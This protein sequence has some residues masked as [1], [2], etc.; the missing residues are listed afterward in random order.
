MLFFLNNNKQI[1]II[2]SHLLQEQE[3]STESMTIGDYFR[4]SYCR[5]MAKN[6]G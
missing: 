5:K 2:R 4:R 3:E 1:V 6:N